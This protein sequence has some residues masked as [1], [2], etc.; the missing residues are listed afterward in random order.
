M[1]LSAVL[2]GTILQHGTRY[3]SFNISNTLKLSNDHLLCPR[4]RCSWN[5]K[6]QF[7]SQPHSDPIRERAMDIQEKKI[8]K[9]EGDAGYQEF[10]LYSFT[11]RRFQSEIWLRL[12]VTIIKFVRI[13]PGVYPCIESLLKYFYLINEQ[14]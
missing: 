11:F 12:M 13:E 14:K 2:L 9:T 10:V 7:C 4:P 5:S 1:M 6:A 3:M 8:H